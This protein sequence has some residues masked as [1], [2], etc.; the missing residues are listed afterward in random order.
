MSAPKA[1]VD[2]G[3]NS[4]K[5]LIGRVGRPIDV[6]YDE[7]VVTRLSEGV[8]AG[9]R[10]APAA[11]ARTLAVLERFVGLARAHGVD[12]L[13]GV[14]TAVLRDAADAPAFVAR[15]AA[16]GLPVE[17]V[18]GDTEAEIV[19]LAAQSELPGL[20]ADAVLLDIGGGSTEIIWP[21]GRESTELGVVRLTER[22]VHDDP[23]GLA[24][25]DRL[26]AAIDARLARLPLP[27]C[28]EVVGSSSS[29][30]LIARLHLGL[31]AHDA[32]R[33]HGCTI[34]TD[35]VAAIADRLALMTQAERVAWPGMDAGRADVIFAGAAVLAGVARRVGA[36]TIR[37]NDRGT[38]YGIFQRAYGG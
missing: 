21:G 32:Q 38:R 31:P 3:S 29:C 23:P 6:I 33:L 7:V 2:I 37:I 13:V 36:P 14:G 34:P 9:G 28:E 19:W 4:V 20:S 1:V 12:A 15:C 10:L 17:I 8:D 22:H 27:A 5:L 30:S 35:G 25:R 26:S 16:L 24:T 11:A 18:D